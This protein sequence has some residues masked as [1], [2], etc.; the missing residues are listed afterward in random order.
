MRL[1]PFKET[2]RLLEDILR[3]LRRR[4]GH[5]ESL[6]IVPTGGTMSLGITAGGALLLVQVI[7]LPGGSI[8]DSPPN[9]ALTCDDSNVVIAA[10]AGDTTGTLFNVSTPA[11]DTATSANLSATGLAGGQ[12]ISS[13][14]IPLAI[15]PGAP[16]PPVFATSLGI[17]AAPVAS[18]PTATASAARVVA[19]G[20]SHT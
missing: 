12:K 19:P 3:F 18:A 6:K 14:P 8:L 10:E 20:K 16:P 15:S 7:P 11:T 1:N 4:F 9:I 2:N 13:G 17:V 5:A